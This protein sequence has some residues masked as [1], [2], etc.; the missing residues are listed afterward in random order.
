MAVARVAALAALLPGPYADARPFWRLQDLLAPPSRALA[1]SHVPHPAVARIIVPERDGTAFGSGT[2][3]DVRDKYGLVVTNHHVVGHA[4]GPIEVVF[5]GGF[6][7]HAR[8]LKM[9]SEWDLAA[10]VI[11]RP[12]EITPVPL[13]ARAP[14]PGDVLT[15]CGYGQGQYRSITGRCTD[16]YAPSV[17]MPRE[18][19]ELDV[20]A[21]QGDSGGPIFNI[22]NELAGVLFGAGQG[23][24]LG[25][26]G[27]RVKGFLA[28]VAPDIGT[29]TDDIV[30]ASADVDSAPRE[31]TAKPQAAEDSRFADWKPAETKQ[32]GVMP[33]AAHE[34]NTSS[35]TRSPITPW[36]DRYVPISACAA[37]GAFF[38]VF[39]RLVK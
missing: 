39:V 27:G 9:D 38:V 21:R 24:T 37:L 19:V 5:P 31:E 34:S 22:K 18:L 17:G 2:L 23:T 3:V 6:R 28:T 30:V 8:S 25:S 7:S 1:E 26:F 11:W 32:V 13:A 35:D 16:Y 15:I 12:E 33:A 10:L 29:A 20:E 36:I 4:S 14:Q